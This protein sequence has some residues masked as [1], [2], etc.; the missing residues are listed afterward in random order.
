MDAIE[1]ERCARALGCT[2]TAC[3]N[4]L[5]RWLHE[6]NHHKPH[7]AVRGRPPISRLTNVP[8]LEPGE[9][10]RAKRRVGSL[11]PV[12]S[13]ASTKSTSVTCPIEECRR[14]RL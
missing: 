8:G 13:L 14:R 5:P 9:W 11:R 4:A 3:R 6:Y 1:A 10:P 7:T 2:E 12:E